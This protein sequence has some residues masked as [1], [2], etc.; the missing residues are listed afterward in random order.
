MGIDIGFDAGAQGARRHVQARFGA[1]AALVQIRLDIGDDQVRRTPLAPARE[2]I[3]GHA[4]RLNV[5]KFGLPIEQ[6]RLDVRP[7]TPG[8][9]GL[10]RGIRAGVAHVGREL[11]AAGTSPFAGRLLAHQISLARDRDGIIHSVAPLGSEM[12][13]GGARPGCFNRHRGK[14]DIPIHQLR[15]PGNGGGIE[16]QQ[17]FM[18]AGPGSR[19]F[20]SAN[21]QAGVGPIGF[22]PRRGEAGHDLH[23]LRR[24]PGGTGGIGPT[25]RLRFNA[26]FS[27]SSF[28]GAGG[29]NAG[30]EP[31]VIERAPGSFGAG[32]GERESDIETL[33]LARV[34]EHA[35]EQGR[36][37]GE[38]NAV[39]GIS[40]VIEAL[41][42]NTGRSWLGAAGSFP[43]ADSGGV[44]DGAGKLDLRAGKIGFKIIQ[45]PFVA[46][47]QA[48]LGLNITNG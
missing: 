21:N 15:L 6:V 34:T 37:L 2:A 33:Q 10:C 39:H 41:L 30:M 38:P 46:R 29:K 35:N 17:Q 36:W 43:V 47:Q 9:I 12:G 26:Q 4:S 8:G 45:P 5:F 31:T 27:A 40:E 32:R 16:R 20:A 18:Y 22:T 14:F 23:I 3:G 7:P 25:A 24:S 11:Q 44:G 28:I 48:K 19:S 13:I 1:E 42:P